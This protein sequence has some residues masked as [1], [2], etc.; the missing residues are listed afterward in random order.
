MSADKILCEWCRTYRE[1]DAGAYYHQKACEC[2]FLTL[3]Q[4]HY[5]EHLTDKGKRKLAE[6]V[7][8]AEYVGD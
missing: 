8:R 4:K 6:A 1:N 3:V 5:G 2:R 7:E